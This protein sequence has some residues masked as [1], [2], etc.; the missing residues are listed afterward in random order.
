MTVVRGGTPLLCLLLVL[1]QAGTG[2]AHELRPAY[3]ELT[4]LDPERYR[5]AWKTPARGRLRLK[6]DVALPD[7]CQNDEEK[8]VERQV[9]AVLERWQVRC[10]GGLG[11]RAIE[12]RGL[13]PSLTNVIVS[14]EASTGRL[15][16]F[17]LSGADPV[18]HIPA[19]PGTATVAR[20]F[21]QLGVEH[22]A[23]GIDHL[24]FVFTLVLL[25]RRPRDILL[26]V[27][28]FTVAHSLTLS[29]ATLLGWRLPAGPVEAAIALSIVFVA[30]E[31]L[32]GDRARSSLITQAP[33]SVAF[34][35]GL[36]HGY[37]FAGALADL[38]L[39]P[40]AGVPA[41]LFFNLGVETGQVLFIAVI[42]ALLWLLGKA[43]PLAPGLRQLPVWVVGVLSSYWFL[44]RAAAI[45]QP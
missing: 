11:G 16:T 41:L 26:A 44:D 28:A 40:G 36:L 9:G 3:L 37:G 13:Q 45:V 30:A 39:P 14:L 42:L 27:T 10:A 34:A 32:R 17:H 4:Q 6:L 25:L 7:N 29:G 20:T 2:N 35:F 5:V 43:P 24:F 12:I 23:L 33:W 38:G 21:W 22:I 8:R 19:T 15:Q 18:L 1:L 31:L